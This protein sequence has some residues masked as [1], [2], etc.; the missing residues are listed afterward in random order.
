MTF[1]ERVFQYC[2]RGTN[3]A[4]LAEPVNALSNAAFLLAA[5]AGFFIVLRRPPQERNAD[6]LLLPVL[7]L[8]IG[9][10][11]LAFHLYANSAAALA[12]VVPISVFMLVYLGLAL[13]RFLGVPPAWTTLLVIG[14]T[15][16]V[17]IT[18]QVRCG[19][20]GVV[21]FNGL[22]SES[23]KPCLNGSLFYFPALAGL[24]A[25]GLALSERGHKAAPWLLSAAA[26]F[27]VS[28]TLRS[29]DF[30]LCDKLVFEGR[31]IGTH[32]A[33]HVLNALVLFLLMRASLEGGP[34]SEV[35]DSRTIPFGDE[36]ALP[37]KDTPVAFMPGAE[38]RAPKP[39]AERVSSANT[40]TADEAETADDNRVASAKAEE[41][42]T[43]D[44]KA[45]R[46]PSFPM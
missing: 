17:A 16:I 34:R 25:I 36:P 44:K 3:E 12:D 7:V 33:W 15:A 5:L 10:G 27:A 19:E 21:S 22:D 35:A 31:K 4:L 37:R 8:F 13:N 9:L 30:A 43:P 32:A 11:S 38:V 2:E 14:F 24:I 18:M 40:E 39:L 45:E 6:Q 42:E 41:A 23:V 46:K 1:G 29:L 26:I 20:G 28:V